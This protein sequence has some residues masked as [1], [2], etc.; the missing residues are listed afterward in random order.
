[1]DITNDNGP[2]VTQFPR[3]LNQKTPI[4][5]SEQ[6]TDTELSYLSPSEQRRQPE[7][8][9]MLNALIFFTIALCI[10]AAFL[11]FIAFP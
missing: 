4:L 11:Y 10:V 6:Y 1:M 9:P 3:T 5:D 8:R 2:K 7:T